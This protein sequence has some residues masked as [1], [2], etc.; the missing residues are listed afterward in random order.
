M[1][2]NPTS[3]TTSNPE[4]L[5]GFKK[6]LNTI[7]ITHEKDYKIELDNGKFNLINLDQIITEILMKE[8]EKEK[9]RRELLG[10]L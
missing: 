8:M 9:L 4:I 5:V 1:N 7:T 3:N 10:K 6:K 2:L